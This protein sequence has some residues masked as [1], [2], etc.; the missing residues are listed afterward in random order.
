MCVSSGCAPRF[1]GHKA[2]ITQ[3]RDAAWLGYLRVFLWRLA[4]PI[5]AAAI[6]PRRQRRINYIASASR[7]TSISI[8]GGEER[9]SRRAAVK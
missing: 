5:P 1:V 8:S 4:F 6:V 9:S 2:T 3:A 7:K